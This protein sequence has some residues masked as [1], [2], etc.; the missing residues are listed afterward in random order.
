MKPTILVRFGNL[1]IGNRLLAGFGVAI[2]VLVGLIAYN[3]TS[4]TEL[5]ELQDEGAGR[6]ADAISVT[7]MAGQGSALYQIVADAVINRDLEVTKR[8]WEAMTSE[9]EGD[10]AHVGDIVDTPEEEEWHKQGAEAYRQ[11]VEVVEREM[12]PLLER[13]ESV[14]QEIRELDGRLDGYAAAFADNYSRIRE[15][16]VREA[17]EADESFDTVGA[18]TIRI[19]IIIA[20]IAVVGLVLVVLFTTRSIVNPIKAMT[21]AMLKLADGNKTVEI[22]ATER[23]DE[24]G[25]MAKAVLVFKD[26]MI[27]ADEMAADQERERAAK[28]QRAQQV[29]E[30]AENFDSAVTGI[31]KTVAAAATELESTAQS[32][33]ATAEQTGH[34]ST[35]VASA[36]EQA[37][38]N[39]QTVASAAEELSNSIQEIG[40]QVAQATEAAK[41]ANDQAQQSNTTVQGLAEG[42]RK[43]GEVVDLINDI[44]EQTNLLALNATIEAARAGDAGKGFAVV[45]SEVKSLA[46]QTAKATEEIATQIGDMQSVTEEAVGAIGSVVGVMEKINEITTSIASAVEQQ[47]AATSEISRNVQEAAKGTQEVTSN[48]AGVSQAAAETGSAANQV[49]S[50]AGDLS[51]QSDSLRGEVE[52]FLRQIKEA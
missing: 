15:S 18:D 31:L 23:K 50:S 38:A 28:E 19:S 32:M 20:V 43:I 16:I 5:A 46:N 37:S 1:K 8:D 6:A 42:A 24:V 22:P 13:S 9:L 4:L 21:G 29:E 12:L 49:L 27:K 34:Q 17:E 44:A 26:N 45:A 51:K 25:E 52:T 41:N 39:V 48:I 36:A 14:A 7:E 33:S 11:F 47:N 40:R 30:L 35:T 10:I 3:Y 2:I